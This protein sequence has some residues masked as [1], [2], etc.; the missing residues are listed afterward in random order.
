MRFE[1]LEYLS[2]IDKWGS[3]NAAAQKLYIT[4]QALSTSM[5]QLED[6]LGKVLFIKKNNKTY[7]TVEG[8]F[9]LEHANKILNEK[10]IIIDYFRKNQE[11]EIPLH[12]HVLSTS[13]VLKAL[14]PSLIV[15]YKMSNQHLILK[16]TESETTKFILERLATE[17]CGI[18]LICIEKQYFERLQDAYNDVLQAEVLGYDEL[19]GVISNKYYD[20]SFEVI[21]GTAYDNSMKTIYNVEITEDWRVEADRKTILQS[22]DIEFHKAML[23]EKG[24]MVSMTRLS[25][26][27]F[28]N[29][30]KYIALPLKDQIFSILYVAVYRKDAE[31]R[32]SDFIKLIRKELYL[33]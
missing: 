13:S 19:I 22:N 7:L 31:E 10:N 12:I 27:S 4:Q 28:F 9:V 33:K 20:G 32:F 30:K 21:D 23:E 25:F 17:Q 1:Q 29:S 2:A 11:D 6:E 3:F 5:R 8:E 24:S 26:E 18:G 14:L 15:Q 16:I